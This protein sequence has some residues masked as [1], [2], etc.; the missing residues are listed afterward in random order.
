MPELFVGV[1]L[2]GVVL[3]GVVA[4]ASVVGVGGGVSDAFGVTCVS[5][6]FGGL[7]TARRDGSFS[8]VLGAVPGVP[9][10][11]ALACPASSARAS[12]AA[13]PGRPSS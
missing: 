4:L 6:I 8:F 10:V 1:V 5:G 2:V 7:I 11:V 9:G 12:S 3:V 13:A